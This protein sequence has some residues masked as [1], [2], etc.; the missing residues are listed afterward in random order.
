MVFSMFAC[1]GINAGGVFCSGFVG[2]GFEVFVAEL[3]L[4]DF[5]SSEKTEEDCVPLSE[6]S[7]WFSGGFCP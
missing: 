2:A 7:V 3:L 1:N 6:F 5:K 4:N